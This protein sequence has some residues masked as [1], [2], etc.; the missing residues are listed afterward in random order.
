MRIL[1][2][3]MVPVL[4]IVLTNNNNVWHVVGRNEKNGGQKMGMVKDNRYSN[5]FMYGE[6]LD[7]MG[8]VIAKHTC[9]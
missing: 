7:L 3:P 5:E 4:D 1:L 2:L 6:S 9:R 8:N